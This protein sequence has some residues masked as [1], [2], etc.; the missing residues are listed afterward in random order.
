M[1]SKLA[2]ITQT[3]QCNKPRLEFFG[4]A[5]V[6]GNL[7]LASGQ[8]QAITHCLSEQ[9]SCHGK[10][11]SRSCSAPAHLHTPFAAFLFLNKPFLSSKIILKCHCGQINLT[12]R[13]G[14]QTDNQSVLTEAW[15]LMSTHPNDMIL[16]SLMFKIRV[17]G[18]GNVA[19]TAHF[20][21]EV[22]FP[23]SFLNIRKKKK[24]P[25]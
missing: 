20:S 13:K 19:H 6:A 9:V 16:N 11:A 7:C 1:D 18:D 24:W 23:P 4:G 14:R 22:I 17:R 10:A 12:M 15:P 25:K 3:L 21:R 8:V 5:V 2:L